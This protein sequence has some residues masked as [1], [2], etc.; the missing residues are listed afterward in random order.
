MSCGNLDPPLFAG[1]N[2]INTYKATFTMYVSDK[3]ARKIQIVKVFSQ[4]VNRLHIRIF[5]S[6]KVFFTTEM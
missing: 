5:F 4:T 2:C 6:T 3:Q 1:D